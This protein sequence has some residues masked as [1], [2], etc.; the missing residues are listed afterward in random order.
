M[1]GYAENKRKNFIWSPLCRDLYCHLLRLCY[2]PHVTYFY[3]TL[4]QLSPATDSSNRQCHPTL[5]IHNHTKR[6]LNP[7][8]SLW[9]LVKGGG[10]L[11]G[12]WKYISRKGFPK[13]NNF[14]RNTLTMWF[15]KQKEHV[16]HAW[17]NNSSDLRTTTTEVYIYR[18]SE[19][20]QER[21]RV[22]TFC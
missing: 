18:F 21:A 5:Q 1:A 2:F 22:F 6:C 7:N 3:M 15:T 12:K 20:D 17:V 13:E 11:K 4:F 10:D 14:S 9:R 19:Q 8:L 16:C